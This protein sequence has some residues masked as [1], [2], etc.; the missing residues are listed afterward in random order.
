[1]TF[2]AVMR[3]FYYPR[4]P[5]NPTCSVMDAFDHYDPAGD[6]LPAQTNKCTL[7]GLPKGTG[8]QG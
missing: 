6:H 2:P 7:H 8:L 1:M 3:H 5:P 4:S